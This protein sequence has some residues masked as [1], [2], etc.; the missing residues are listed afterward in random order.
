MMIQQQLQLFIELA[1]QIIAQDFIKKPKKGGGNLANLTFIN[2]IFGKFAF[3]PQQKEKIGA[4]RDVRSVHYNV[5][6]SNY[7]L[8]FS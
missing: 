2:R 6:L 1:L 3:I 7:H 4:C 8:L 5:N